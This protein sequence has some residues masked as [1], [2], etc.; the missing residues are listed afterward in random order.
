MST[1]VLIK[2]GEEVL[3][4]RKKYGLVAS[5]VEFKFGYNNFSCVLLYLIDELRLE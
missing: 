4:C 1:L 2:F 5:K 3:V